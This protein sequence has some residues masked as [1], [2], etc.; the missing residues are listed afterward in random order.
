ML[1]VVFP[2]Q[3]FAEIP[4]EWTEIQFVRHDIGYGGKATTVKNFHV[5]RK[6]FLRAAEAAWLAHINAK[7]PKVKVDVR[8]RGEAWGSKEACQIWDPVDRML[9]AEIAKK[10]PKATVLPTP[11]FLLAKEEAEEMLG[12]STSRFSHA[13]FYGEMRRRTGILMT[14]GKPLG[15]KLRYDEENRE[16]IPKGAVLPAWDKELRLRQSPYI[17]AAAKE[18]AAEGPSLGE[19]TGDLVFPTTHQGAQQALDRFVSQRLAKFGPHED[20]IQE[21]CDFLYHSVLSATINIGL[22]TPIDVLET[23]VDYGLTHKIPL[24]SLEGFVA[25]VLGWREYMRAVY[26]KMPTHPKDRLGHRRALGPAWYEGTTGLLPVDTAIARVRENAYLHHIER[27]MIVGN[28]MFLAEIRPTEV[29]RWFM[30]M[31]ADSWDWVMVGNVYYM[32]QWAS[33]AITTKPYISSS[34]Y[35]LRMSDYGKGDWCAAW[36]ALYW[37]AIHRHAALIRKNY[38]MAAQVSFWEKKSAAEKKE[39]QQRAAEALKHM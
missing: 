30:E 17:A 32:S 29:Y 38:R 21:D 13:G 15:G 18:I 39:I 20:A 31:F 35:V 26:V 34:A 16:K 10:C 14:A 24:P 33:D 5:A 36:D 12:T 22:L 8:K 6:V 2:H 37:S 27:L 28:A 25:Q 9:E 23:V 1:G 3:L 4:T 19:W 7:Y 11:A